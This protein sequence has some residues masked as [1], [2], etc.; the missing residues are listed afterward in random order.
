MV[1]HV[2]FILIIR[3]LSIS[4]SKKD[5]NLRQRRWMELLKDYDCTILYHPGKANIVADTLSRKSIGSLA[6]IIKVK[7][8]T[9]KGFQ[10][11]VNGRVKFKV[12]G[13]ELLLAQVQVCSTL[14][15]SIKLG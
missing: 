14:V 13:A 3:A 6:Y 2:R 9:I 8:P 7:R 15:D 5:L 1:R 10:E 4:F 11:L 12:T